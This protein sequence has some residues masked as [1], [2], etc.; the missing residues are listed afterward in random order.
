MVMQGPTSL[1]VCRMAHWYPQDYPVL[2][3]QQQQQLGRH[4]AITY[5]ALPHPAC[6]LPA[7]YPPLQ[8]AYSSTPVAVNGVHHVWVPFNLNCD[9]PPYPHFYGQ[10]PLQPS[11][12]AGQQIP[13]REPRRS[14]SMARSHEIDP[15]QM[16]WPESPMSAQSFSH[17]HQQRSLDWAI[18]RQPISRRA[19]P[20]CT[21]APSQHP[22]PA[23]SNWC[24]QHPQALNKQLAHP[25]PCDDS[26]SSYSA[27]SPG[28]PDMA[29]T[30]STPA[31]HQAGSESSKSVDAGVGTSHDTHLTADLATD[32]EHVV[33]GTEPAWQW[34]TLGL[35]RDVMAELPLHCRKRCRLVCKRWRATMDLSVQVAILLCESCLT[36]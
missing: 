1:G 7:L 18:P 13:Y 19:P 25:S 16:T 2:Q 26:L 21:A 31:D 20:N 6:L 35:L 11:L 3:Q 34:L 30:R 29:V 4:S 14:A 10:M 15:L 9:P 27:V 28:T 32:E 22:S 36:H 8:Y 17:H 33:D 24:P 12:N 23:G 5:G